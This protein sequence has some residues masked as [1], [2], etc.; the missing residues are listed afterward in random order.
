ML[1]GTFESER[2]SQI[3]SWPYNVGRTE[4]GVDAVLFGYIGLDVL[5]TYLDG[6]TMQGI[7]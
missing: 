2:V 7:C 4:R 3:D 5:V 6:K 1:V